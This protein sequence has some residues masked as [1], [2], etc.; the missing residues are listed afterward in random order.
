M[1][2][3]IYR[4]DAFEVLVAYD[5]SRSWPDY[6]IVAQMNDLAVFVLEDGA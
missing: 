1:K 6:S 5:W 3:S 2:L 4:L